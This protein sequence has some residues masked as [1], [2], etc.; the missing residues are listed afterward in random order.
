MEEKNREDELKELAEKYPPDI[1][2]MA[3]LKNG[4]N[5]ET[6][7]ALWMF[8]VL[9]TLRRIKA[10]LTML[11]AFAS[12]FIIYTII[13]FLADNEIDRILDRVGV[14]M[15]TIV[16]MYVINKKYKPKKRNEE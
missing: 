8:H 15:I 9:F 12:G 5:S 2:M 14:F 7:E 4:K 3:F 11:T 1:L 13:A 16:I 6:T 10:V